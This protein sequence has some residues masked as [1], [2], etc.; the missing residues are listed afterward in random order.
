MT[1][2]R[3]R[4]GFRRRYGFD[5]DATKRG[6]ARN[7]TLQGVIGAETAFFTPTMVQLE[8]L[9]A[10]DLSK[11]VQQWEQR[12]WEEVAS[13]LGV[14]DIPEKETKQKV[15]RRKKAARLVRRHSDSDEPAPVGSKDV[16]M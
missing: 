7:E 4:V 16:A 14:H 2:G 12:E 5:P 10:V 11:Q 3:R 13:G 8:K 1:R 9:N 6:G 15:Q